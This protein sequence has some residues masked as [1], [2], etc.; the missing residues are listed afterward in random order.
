MYGTLEPELHR[1][2][3]AALDARPATLS[4]AAKSDAFTAIGLRTSYF[5][6]VHVSAP[7]AHS[8]IGADEFVMVISMSAD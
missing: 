6:L 7:K 4:G 8:S 3:D 2:G 1:E 5:P